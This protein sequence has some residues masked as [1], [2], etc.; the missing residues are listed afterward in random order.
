MMKN[1]S[2]WLGVYG[3][4]QTFHIVARKCRPKSGNRQN[5]FGQKFNVNAPDIKLQ[6]NDYYYILFVVPVFSHLRWLQ[7]E[8]F[9]TEWLT[10]VC[11]CLFID[12]WKD[13]SRTMEMDEWNLFWI[14][15]N[16][17]LRC[18]DLCS[19]F[20]VSL[21][22]CDPILDGAG[23]RSNSRSRLT[24]RKRVECDGYV[25]DG[26]ASTFPPEKKNE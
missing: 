4:H 20:R 10:A 13:C 18:L 5:S 6:Y 2:W 3:I 8:K 17:H 11:V 19:Q 23:H 21:K 7:N 1:S 15:R 16:F 24:I 12:T 26:I 22:F 14:E 9:T 25:T